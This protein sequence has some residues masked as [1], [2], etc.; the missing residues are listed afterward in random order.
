M[1]FVAGSGG[2]V[3]EIAVDCGSRCWWTSHFEGTGGKGRLGGGPGQGG[4]LEEGIV[5]SGV[6]RDGRMVG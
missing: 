1:K 3:R 2:S 5:M 6:D 4:K